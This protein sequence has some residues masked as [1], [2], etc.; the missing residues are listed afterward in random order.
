MELSYRIIKSSVGGGWCVEV[1]R[2]GFHV[3]TYPLNVDPSKKRVSKKYLM[4]LLPS[5]LEHLAD[6]KRW[7]RTVATRWDRFA[8][9]YIYY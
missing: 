2:G 3:Q 5:T 8:D 1:R 9:L 7:T 6:P 4:S